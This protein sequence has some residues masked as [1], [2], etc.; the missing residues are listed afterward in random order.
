MNA[1]TSNAMYCR[2]RG[3]PRKSV[4]KVVDDSSQLL[5][6]DEENVGPVLEKLLAMMQS[7]SMLLSALK[8]DLRPSNMPEHVVANKRDAATTQLWRAFVA[9]QKSFS[10]IEQ[11]AHSSK[12]A[13]KSSWEPVDSLQ[14]FVK[15]SNP[16]NAT[17]SVEC[18]QARAA[19]VIEVSESESD[20][21]VEC[22]RPRVDA[23]E[24]VERSSPPASE[25]SAAAERVCSPVLVASSSD[26]SIAPLASTSA[27]SVNT[28]SSTSCE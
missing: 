9:Y 6:L 16:A 27:V 26:S 7:M 15:H 11:F 22:K 2:R 12:T 3:R 18:S 19:D 5:P 4:S 10:E 23:A 8:N 13:N 25:S 1:S 17:R 24:T 14:S 20:E 21:D 28:V